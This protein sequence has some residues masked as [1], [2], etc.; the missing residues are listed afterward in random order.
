[1]SFDFREFVRNSSRNFSFREVPFSTRFINCGTISKRSRDRSP[2][3]IRFGTWIFMKSVL[4]GDCIVKI[5]EN[6]LDE[7]RRKRNFLI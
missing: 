2:I 4:E 5:D 7:S 1:M 6:S 3:P